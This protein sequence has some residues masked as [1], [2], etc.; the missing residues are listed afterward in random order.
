[1]EALE[2]KYPEMLKEFSN[3]RKEV[4]LVKSKQD[5]EKEQQAKDILEYYGYEVSPSDPRFPILFERMLEAKKKVSNYHLLM[6]CYFL[7]LFSEI[8]VS[9]SRLASVL[10]QSGF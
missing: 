9:F 1:M 3:S 10:A 8:S 2:D 6:K 4:V 5:L 7:S